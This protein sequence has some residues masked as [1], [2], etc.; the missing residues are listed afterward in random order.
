MNI[1]EW[2]FS[3]YL[4]FMKETVNYLLIVIVLEYKKS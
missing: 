2:P 3:N 1:F 4:I